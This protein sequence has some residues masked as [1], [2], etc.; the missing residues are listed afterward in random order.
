MDA[1]HNKEVVMTA[2]LM[3]R[4]NDIK[5]L[6]ALFADDIEWVTIDS[7]VIPFAGPCHGKAQVANYFR[8]LSETQDAV[9]F[10]P[11]TFTAEDDRVVVTGV[12][13]WHVKATGKTYDNPWAHAFQLREGKIVRLQ[14]YNN[15]AAAEAAFR[16]VAGAARE[17]QAPLRH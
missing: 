15:T 9:V 17:K 6:L 4:N 14:Q 3:Y 7:D 1:Q 13:T 11:Q 8:Q 12:S 5:G 2:Y 10:E 16:P